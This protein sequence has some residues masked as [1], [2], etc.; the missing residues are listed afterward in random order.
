MNFFMHMPKPLLVLS[1]LKIQHEYSDDTWNKVPMGAVSCRVCTRD[2]KFVGDF[3]YRMKTGQVGG[4]FIAEPYR[5]RGLEQQMLIHM[6]KDMQD[7]GAKQIWEV[8]PDEA[9][10]GQRFY[11]ALWSFAFKRSRVHP[12]VTGM[13]YAMD[14]PT[15]LRSLPIVP[16]IGVYD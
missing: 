1:T 10:M 13:G 9:I 15:D 3:D 6:M 4:F 5:C 11:S 16:G 7:F 2:G 12:S 14:I 8:V